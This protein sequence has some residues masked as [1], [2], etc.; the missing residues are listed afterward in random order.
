MKDLQVQNKTQSLNTLKFSSDEL[1]SALD[2]VQL[3]ME[4]S[5]TPF[6]LLKHT[7][8]TIFD[9]GD[10]LLDGDSIELGILKKNLMRYNTSTL[11]TLMPEHT[12]T[13]RK[14]AFKHKDVPVNIQI[15]HNDYDFL[16]H[17]DNKFYYIENFNI[18][19]PF[20]EYYKVRETIK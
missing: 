4:K 19:N 8:R 20:E 14:I 11:I 10:K 16:K 12:W 3:I 15:I 6:V 9:G 2:F 18:P 5:M 13:Q 1:F 17:P 7:G